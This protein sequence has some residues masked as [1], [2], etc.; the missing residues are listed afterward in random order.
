MFLSPTTPGKIQLVEIPERVRNTF[1]V[2]EFVVIVVVV[3]VV[4]AI[5]VGIVVGVVV[6][7]VV[8]ELSGSGLLRTMKLWLR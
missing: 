8:L 1:V 7:V 5:V 4:V 6:V 3:V 2:L